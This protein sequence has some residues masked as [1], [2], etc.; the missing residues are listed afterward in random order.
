MAERPEASAEPVGIL[1]LA[2]PLVI[3]FWVRAGFTIVD[4]DKIAH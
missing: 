1:R 4:A 2:A 3:S